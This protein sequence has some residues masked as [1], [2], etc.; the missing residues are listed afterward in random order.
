MK[1]HLYNIKRLSNFPTQCRIKNWTIGNNLFTLICSQAR[2]LAISLIRLQS[3]TM[4]QMILSR[5][6]RVSINEVK[7]RSYLPLADL[8]HQTE[9][10]ANFSTSVPNI[11]FESVLYPMLIPMWGWTMNDDVVSQIKC[12]HKDFAHKCWCAFSCRMFPPL[13]LLH[14]TT[15]SYTY[16]RCVQGC[17]KSGTYQGLMEDL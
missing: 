17:Q 2:S 13:I 8:E 3:K 4:I 5:L 7:R 12:W 6:T 1:K 16:I 14:L 10:G 15:L 9:L 11:L